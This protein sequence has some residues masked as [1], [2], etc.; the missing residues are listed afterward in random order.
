MRYLWKLIQN[1]T[2][3]SWISNRWLKYDQ[4]FLERYYTSNKT[5]VNT[6]RLRLAGRCDWCCRT[7]FPPHRYSFPCQRV[8][9]IPWWWSTHGHGPKSLGKSQSYSGWHVEQH[10]ITK[11]KNHTVWIEHLSILKSVV[12]VS[13]L[14]ITRHLVYFRR[15][16]VLCMRQSR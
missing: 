5:T 14:S 15:H 9:Q 6:Y 4:D 12:F 3:A 10:L 13:L 11:N 1:D 2:R 8:L 16:I 7:G